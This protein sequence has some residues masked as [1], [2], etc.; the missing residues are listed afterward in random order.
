MT[1]TPAPEEAPKVLPFKAHREPGRIREKPRDYV[2]DCEHR[3]LT[4]DHEGRAVWCKKCKKML[5]PYHAL[6]LVSRWMAERDYKYEAIQEYE[7]KEKER[8]QREQARREAK[9]EERR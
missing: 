7:K 2:N 6:K 5:D 9:K 1:E 3:Q 4:L 8:R